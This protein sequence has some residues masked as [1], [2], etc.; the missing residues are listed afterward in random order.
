MTDFTPFSSLLGGV[1]IG[2]SAS[3]LL[4]ADGQVAGISGILG[5]LFRRP[6]PEVAWRWW[7]VAGLLLG[8]LCLSAFRP[9]LFGPS[10]APPSWGLAGTV[11][12]G[13]FV[14]I[15]TRLGSG[16]TSGHGVCGLSRLSL[17]S[18]VATSTF[19][20][21]AGLVTFVVRHVLTVTP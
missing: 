6:G 20:G 9:G 16:C 18:L 17:R 4:F 7:F 11:A 19:M 21:T 2:T 8:G 12:A 3:V 14:G 5:G 10:A 13:L 1:L 15:G